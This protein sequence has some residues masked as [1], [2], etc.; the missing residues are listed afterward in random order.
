[1]KL[2]EYLL[3]CVMAS[4]LTILAT[5]AVPASAAMIIERRV[6]GDEATELS[7][8]DA[9]Q[10]LGYARTDD[11]GNPIDFGGMEGDTNDSSDLEL[12]ANRP[13]PAAVS[14]TPGNGAQLI[15]IRWLD[16]NIPKGA[17]ITNA[18]VQFQVNEEDKSPPNVP[19]SLTI[20]GEL[21]PNPATFASTP[22]NITSRPETTTKTQWNDIPVWAFTDLN[23]GGICVG[24]GDEGPNQRTPDLSAIIQEIV[25]LPGWASGNPI[26]LTFAPQT[27]NF[28]RTANSW[29]SGNTNG[30]NNVGP[31]L[32]IEFVPEPSTLAFMTMGLTGLLT[33]GRRREAGAA[34]RSMSH[35]HAVVG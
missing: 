12:G 29:E 30:P 13:P 8:D 27:T 21:S 15:G 1:M 3:K 35:D 4:A 25:D 20:A 7:N 9:E 14:N 2:S 33:L 16:I 26:V 19:A 34:K 18:Y 6:V 24:C 28:N 32:H 31:L 10:H 17:T 23:Q 22:L 11:E 5:C